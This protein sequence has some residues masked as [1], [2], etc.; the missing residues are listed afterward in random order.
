MSQRIVVY[1]K[2]Y[3]FLFIEVESSIPRLLVCFVNQIF[4]KLVHMFNIY[5]VLV[6]FQCVKVVLITGFIS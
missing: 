6:H 1:R 4:I 5:Q 2:V 3:L